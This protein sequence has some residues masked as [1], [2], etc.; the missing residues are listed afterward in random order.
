MNK[1]S[2]YNGTIKFDS[3]SVKKSVMSRKSRM[4]SS[5]RRQ[6]R[7]F[8]SS[9]NESKLTFTQRQRIKFIHGRSLDNFEDMGFMVLSDKI[10]FEWLERVCLCDKYEEENNNEE[11][12]QNFFESL[13]KNF[14]KEKKDLEEANKYLENKG[15]DA[16][17]KERPLTKYVQFKITMFDV[18]RFIKEDRKLNLMTKEII[19]WNI[20]T[21]CV[22][23]LIICRILNLPHGN[24]TPQTVFKKGRME[25]EISPPI[26]STINIYKRMYRP[27]K[28]QNSIRN[29]NGSVE[30]C[31]APEYF[32]KITNLYKSM[33]IKC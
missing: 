12:K 28:N 19:I 1:G 11:N 20:L 16:I 5:L 32:T 18:S 4:T 22:Q 26:F 27:N 29:Y 17:I 6:K 2:V 13:V 8:G 24:L 30:F 33:M 9:Y 7:L 15:Y 31:V 25:W 14:D 3:A 23:G 21:S 10:E